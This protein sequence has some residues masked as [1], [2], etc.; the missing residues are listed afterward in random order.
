MTFVARA[1][2]SSS[3]SDDDAMSC[4]SRRRSDKEIDAV[5]PSPFGLMGVAGNLCVARHRR[6]PYIA[7]S[8]LLD[9][10]SQN[11]SANVLVF[12]G[13]DTSHNG[14]GSETTNTF[15]D[16]IGE[17]RSGLEKSET[18]SDFFPKGRHD[19]SKLAMCTVPSNLLILLRL[20]LFC[21]PFEGWPADCS[22]QQAGRQGNEYIEGW[23]LPM[24]LMVCGG[25]Q[26]CGLD[27]TA[28]R[29][30]LDGS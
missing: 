12:L 4:A 3:R 16:L 2:A 24:G 8:S 1:T 21:A 19:F 10:P 23:P 30:C 28:W 26:Q 25:G 20:Q 14:A 6:C 27:A 18:Q 5:P 22:G 9:L 7:S 29:A 15:C 13:R 11:P 17:L